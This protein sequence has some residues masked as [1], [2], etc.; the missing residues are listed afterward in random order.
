MIAIENNKYIALRKLAQR[1]YDN[2]DLQKLWKMMNTVIMIYQ[3]LIKKLFN[4]LENKLKKSKSILDSSDKKR[5]R[6]SI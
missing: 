3:S 5:K 6:I 4:Y 1:Y 2:G